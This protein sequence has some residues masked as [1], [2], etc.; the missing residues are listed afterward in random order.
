MSTVTTAPSSNLP[1]GNTV[2]MVLAFAVA[3]AAVVLPPAEQAAVARVFGLPAMN[4]LIFALAS[5]IAAALITW[6]ILAGFGLNRVPVRLPQRSRDVRHVRRSREI[7]APEASADAMLARLRKRT[8]NVE[9]APAE[10]PASPLLVKGEMPAESDEA[11]DEGEAVATETV[12]SLPDA[13]VLELVEPVAEASP[14]DESVAS[15]EW[16]VEPVT[17]IAAPSPSLL[18]PVR[19]ARG[20]SEAEEM[21]ATLADAL[22]TLQRMVARR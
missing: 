14:A 4:G 11:T 21:D 20:D 16:P 3:T 12:A 17:L 6:P 10:A 9:A 8:E 7:P 18:P 13:D 5:A 15:P 22:G 2:A 19:L 1:L